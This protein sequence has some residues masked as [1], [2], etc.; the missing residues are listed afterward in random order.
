M[1]QKDS[2]WRIYFWVCRGGVSGEDAEHD[3]IQ[4]AG[5]FKVGMTRR[6]DPMER[7]SELGSASVHVLVADCFRF[8]LQ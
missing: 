5:V 4:C 8:L 1:S 7:V 3:R 2:F 6:L